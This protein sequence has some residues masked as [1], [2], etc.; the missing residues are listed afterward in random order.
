MLPAESTATSAPSSVPIPPAV[1]TQLMK[2]SG[3]IGMKMALVITMVTYHGLTEIQTGLESITNILE[4]K[5]HALL[6][7]VIPGRTTF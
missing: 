3:P 2:L 4:T 6:W 5:M 7:Q 1:E